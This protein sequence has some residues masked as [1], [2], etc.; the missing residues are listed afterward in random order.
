MSHVLGLES[1]HGKELPLK[2]TPITG[3][4]ASSLQSP[5]TI[6]PA[7]SDRDRDR[8]CSEEKAYRV[9]LS[10]VPRTSLQ[11]KIQADPLPSTQEINQCGL[12]QRKPSEKGH[13]VQSDVLR[14]ASLATVTQSKL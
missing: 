9:F 6:I 2:L 3:S 11:N 1:T 8:S 14:L 13:R 5:V 12:S 4:L 7:P 10:S